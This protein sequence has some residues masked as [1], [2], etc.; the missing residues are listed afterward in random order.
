MSLIIVGVGDAD[1]AAMEELDA[2]GKLV[3]WVEQLRIHILR[4]TRLNSAPPFANLSLTEKTIVCWYQIKILFSK[5]ALIVLVIFIIRITY[6]LILPKV[7]YLPPAL[8][9][10]GILFFRLLRFG[11]LVAQR[12]IVQFVEMRRLICHFWCLYKSTFLLT[13]TTND[14]LIKDVKS[15]EASI[16][17]I[18]EQFL[19]ND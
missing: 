16:H 15:S 8:L 14:A 3:T 17:W 18:L 5:K 1:F 13:G 2:D 10:A 11:G 6:Y 9:S 12:D 19:S 7:T 4:E